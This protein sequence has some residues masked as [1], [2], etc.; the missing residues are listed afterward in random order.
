MPDKH[1]QRNAT[2]TASCSPCPWR[3]LQRYPLFSSS[4][5]HHPNRSTLP[6]PWQPPL[7]SSPLQRKNTTLS[8]PNHAAPARIDTHTW[9]PCVRARPNRLPR[10]SHHH[11][12]HFPNP[13]WHPTHHKRSPRRCSPQRRGPLSLSQIRTRCR[14]PPRR[15]S[16]RIKQAVSTGTVRVTK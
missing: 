8:V 5:Y 3:P 11:T 14:I 10:H 15:R 4:I 9:Q 1:A 2:L 7:V 12:I 6:A 16:T 13:H